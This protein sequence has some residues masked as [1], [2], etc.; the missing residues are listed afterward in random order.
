MDINTI[1]KCE[2]YLARRVPALGPDVADVV[3]EILVKL[4]P[5]ELDGYTCVALWRRA[6][7]VLRKRNRVCMETIDDPTRPVVLAG[8]AWSTPDARLA[9][10]EAEK[11]ARKMLRLLRAVATAAEWELICHVVRHEKL[12]LEPALEIVDYVGRYLRLARSAGDPVWSGLSVNLMESLGLKRAALDRR[13]ARLAAKW[14]QVGA[15]CAAGA[16]Q[17]ARLR[18]VRVR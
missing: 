6:I 13:K 5:A 14:Q 8:R 3:Q 17:L 15:A 12:A 10:G 7:D 9:G 18:E 4:N 1:R 11:V 16:L 2:N